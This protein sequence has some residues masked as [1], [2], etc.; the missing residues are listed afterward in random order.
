MENK[1][2]KYFKKIKKKLKKNKSKIYFSGLWK[3]KK[4][5]KS[6]FF[7]KANKI[8]IISN[9]IKSQGLIE[10]LRNAIQ[11]ALNLDIKKN[12]S[13]N[14]TKIFFEG[15]F[16]YLLKGKIK[17]ILHKNEKIMLDGMH[18]SADAINLVNYA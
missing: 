6:F 18:P 8:K 17:N 15:R 5:G 9:N 14:Y 7:N 4:R 11:I 10:N 3:I 1:K 16:Q 13:T 12:Y 2:K